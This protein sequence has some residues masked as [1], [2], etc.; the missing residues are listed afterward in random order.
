MPSTPS[1]GSS[2]GGLRMM[3]FKPKAVLF[4]FDFTL[5]DSSSAIVECVNHAMQELGLPIPPEE[6]VRHSIGLSLPETFYKLTGTNKADRP[7][8]AS[9]AEAFQRHFVRHADEIMVAGAALYDKTPATVRS[10]YES[11]LRLGVVT[12]KFRYRIEAI[13]AR[14]GLQQYFEVIVGADDVAQPKPDPEGLLLA[15]G[16]LGIREDECLY[17]GDS[18]TDARAAQAAGIRFVGV[19]T[20]LLNAKDFAPYTPWA[21]LDDVA[22]LPAMLG[23]SFSG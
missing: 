18:T 4:D 12:T 15:L 1:A 9:Q 16:R 17:V 13:L 20:G 7:H 8:L 23:L 22:A 14:D 21:V 11:G 3:V 2:N 19:R 10:L 5:G 6:A